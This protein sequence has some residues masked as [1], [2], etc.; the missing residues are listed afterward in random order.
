MSDEKKA[1]RRN[2]RGSRVSTVVS[3]SLVVFLLGTLAVL[4]LH[5]QQLGRYVRENMEL[6]VMIRPE[7]DSVQVSGL[8]QQV[9]SRPY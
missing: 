3:I 1:L 8:L 4:L 9:R 5:A 2:Q 7:A 6:S